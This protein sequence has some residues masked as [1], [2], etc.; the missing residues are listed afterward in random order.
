MK[1]INLIFPKSIGTCLFP[2][3]DVKKKEF[4]HRL[5]K[6]TSDELVEKSEYKRKM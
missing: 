1:M 5:K 4:M 2:N 3:L 6:N